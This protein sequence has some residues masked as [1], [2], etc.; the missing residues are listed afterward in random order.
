LFDCIKNLKMSIMIKFSFNFLINCIIR[1]AIFFLDYL[2]TEFFSGRYYKY[3]LY[4]TCPRLIIRLYILIYKL[5]IYINVYILY[6]YINICI[7]YMHTYIFWYSIDVYVKSFKT[8]TKHTLH[9]IIHFLRKFRTMKSF[10]KSQQGYSPQDT[11]DLRI[12]VFFHLMF[13]IIHFCVFERIMLCNLS[14]RNYKE[15]MKN[16][17]ITSDNVY[18]TFFF[19]LLLLLF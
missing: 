1:I 9:Y 15:C 19:L 11:N 14:F 2:K 17:H 13:N 18:F 3:M 12:Q 10:K 8:E 7:R 5:Y 4:D 6:R 16:N